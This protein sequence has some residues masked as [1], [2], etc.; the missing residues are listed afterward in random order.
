MPPEENEATQF[1]VPET[2]ASLEAVP[3]QFR[4]LYV[5]KNG[6]FAF[7]D[8]SVIA[9]SMEHA[10][11]ERDEARKK[12]ASVD[13]WEKLGRSPEEIETLL[14]KEAEAEETRARKRGDWDTYKL[15]MAEE[16]KKN[17]EKLVAEH[18]RIAGEKDERLAKMQGTL[19]SRLIDAEAASAIAEAKGAVGLLLPHVKQHS[20]LVEQDGEFVPVVVNSKGEPRVN[21]KGEHLTIKDLVAE[22]RESDT[23]ARAFDGSGAG[24]GGASPNRSAG[25]GIRSMSLQEF[26]RLPPKERAARMAQ[27]MT[28]SE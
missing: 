9:R 19:E 13:R 1:H 12:A 24:G 3:E 27:G 23:F 15:Q 17:V 11:R 14:A 8:P 5:E 28:L 4:G 22:M 16:H 25:G 20:R 6:S 2:L 10:K 18:S 21:A 26:N 7:Q